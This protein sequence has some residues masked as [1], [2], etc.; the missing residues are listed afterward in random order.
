[1]LMEILHLQK[2]PKITVRADHI[3]SR[4]KDNHQH[5]SFFKNK[6]QE[7]N[8]SEAS[9]KVDSSDSIVFEVVIYVLKEKSISLGIDS[10]FRGLD[11]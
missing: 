4:D 3:G 1:M 11:V 8:V 10:V 2:R 6:W 9:I 7:I 5:N